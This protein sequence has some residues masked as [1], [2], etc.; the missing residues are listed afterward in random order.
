MCVFS[1]F[2]AVYQAVETAT[3]IEVAIK[4][5]TVVRFSSDFGS[6]CCVS[7]CCF[8]AFCFAFLSSKC[9]KKVYCAFLSVSLCV[10]V[11]VTGQN[12]ILCHVQH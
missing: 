2:G 5:L 9:V 10:C 12:R 1:S 7:A 6:F 3:G 8:V 4:K 11:G